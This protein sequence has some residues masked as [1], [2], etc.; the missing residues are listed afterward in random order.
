MTG[1]TL[2]LFW[3]SPIVMDRIS[4]ALATIAILGLTGLAGWWVANRPVFSVKR[5]VVDTMQHPLAH[6]TERQIQLALTEAVS[7]TV[8]STDLTAIHRTV[9]ALPWVRRATVRR[10]WPNRLL[11]RVEEHQA[12]AKWEGGR[13]LVNQHGEAFV[14]S[15]SEHS[16]QCRLLA[17]TG[18]AG[19]Q[20]QVLDRAREL[21][22]W[23]KPLNLA[24]TKLTLSAQYAYTA[25]LENGLVLELG[26]DT[27]STPVE[28][29]VRTFVKSQPWLDQQLQASNGWAAVTRI[30]LR[31]AT[32]YAFKSEASTNEK[33][34]NSELLTPCI[35]TT[36]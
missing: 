25:E 31:Y 33:P 27:L 17:L 12:V 7:G 6:V 9:Q 1:S 11:I 32:G 18:P 19:S 34:A 2:R 20:R 15:A 23:I 29:R 4:G 3:H 35:E 16:G 13:F 36:A 8:L 26:R 30:D 10:I 21:M 24:L 14:A 28:E 22:D 5:V